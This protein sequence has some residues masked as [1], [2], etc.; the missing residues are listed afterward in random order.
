MVRGDRGKQAALN[1]V[2]SLELKK[3]AQTLVAC[4]RKAMD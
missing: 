3:A 1:G 4:R 2:G